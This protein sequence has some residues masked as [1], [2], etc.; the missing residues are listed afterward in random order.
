MVI[1]AM[2]VWCGFVRQ[3]EELV[4]SLLEG[5]TIMDALHSGYILGSMAAGITLAV[6]TDTAPKVICST[7]T[8]EL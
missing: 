4:T 5:A 3:T 7:R 1:V 8:R 6:I 2:S